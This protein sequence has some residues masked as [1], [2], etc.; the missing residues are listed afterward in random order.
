MQVIALFVLAAVLFLIAPLIG[1]VV[2]A[3]AGMVVG[4]VFDDTMA[5]LAKLIGAPGTPA[6]QLGAMLGFVAGF[7]RSSVSSSK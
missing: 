7:F 4:W 3:F 6:W 1:I 2:G 5:L